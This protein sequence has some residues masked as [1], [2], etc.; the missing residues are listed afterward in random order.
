MHKNVEAL[1]GRLATDPALRKRFASDAASLLRELTERGFELTKVEIDA[2]AS[3]DP[4]A[5]SAFAA[6]L[7]GRLRKATLHDNEMS[8]DI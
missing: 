4:R 6:A 7:D 2:L 1:L 3:T 8:E 5:L